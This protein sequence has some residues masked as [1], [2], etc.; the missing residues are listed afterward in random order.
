MNLT[1]TLSQPPYVHAHLSGGSALLNGQF[2]SPTKVEQIRK[3]HLEDATQSSSPFKKARVTC[4][5]EESLS[6]KAIEYKKEHDLTTGRNVSIVLFPSP[7]SKKQRYMIAATAGH[8][9][10][11]HAEL[12]VLGMLPEN[13]KKIDLLYTERQPCQKGS[14]CH[15]KLKGILDPSVEV[16]YS[17]PYPI[18]KEER[19]NSEAK[20][21][22]LQQEHGIRAARVKK[23]VKKDSV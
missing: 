8:P 21:R 19:R 14:D 23:Q 10:N 3:R 4:Y 20:F 16:S 2:G 18:D 22:Q 9:C 7:K 17:I 1:A 13:I 12:K 15:R 6:K 5:G 11:P